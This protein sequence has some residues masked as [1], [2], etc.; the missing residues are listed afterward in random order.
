MPRH[1][2]PDVVFQV[3]PK[4]LA[5]H[6]G[7]LDLRTRGKWVFHRVDLLEMSVWAMVSSRKQ[8][9]WVSHGSPC[10]SPMTARELIL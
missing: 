9:I 5:E 8:L 3:L 2:G 10:E 7:E 1:A 4:D 6:G